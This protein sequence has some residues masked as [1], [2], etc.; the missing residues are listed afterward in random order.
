M[1]RGLILDQ[2]LDYALFSIFIA[3]IPGLFVRFRLDGSQSAAQE[4]FAVVVKIGVR[5]LFN[6]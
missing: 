3:Q 5:Q 4:F 1:R 6:N 2:T